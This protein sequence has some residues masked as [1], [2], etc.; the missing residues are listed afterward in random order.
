MNNNIKDIYPLTPSQEGM[1]AQYFRN[2]DTKTYHLQN[3][4][5]INK[6]TDIERLKKSVELLSLRHQVLKSAFTVLKS[7]AIKQ[8]ILQN[9]I[10]EFTV[11]GKEEPYSQAVLEETVNE[12][13]EKPLDLQKDSLFRV[14]VI[15]FTDARFVLMH[16]HHI[17][18]DGWCL[19][20]LI[21]DLQ[22][23]YGELQEGKSIEKLTEEIKSEVAL[24]TSYAQYANWIRKQNTEDVKEYW[25]TLLSDCSPAHIFGKEKKDNSKNENI[26][27]FT[28]PLSNELSQHIEQFARE[29]RVSPN[30]VFECVFSIALQKYSGS[31]DILFDKIIS[32]RSIPLKN[33]ENT[34]GPFINTVPVRI[35]ANE[36]STVSDLLKKTQEQ[37]INANINGILPL[38]EI[39]KQANIDAKSVD[40]LFVFENYYTGDGS[41]IENGPLSPK[42]ISF[43]E[44]TEFNLTVTILKDINGYAIRASYAEEMYTQRE[45]HSF[46]NGYISVLD[47]SLNETTLIKDISA[48]TKE[49]KEQINSFNETEYIY[50]IEENTTLYSLFESQATK[51]SDKVCI[52]ANDKEITYKEF[53]EF[54]ERIDNNI[55][56]V[57][58]EEKSVIAV[59]CERSFE[60]YGAIYGII[61]GGNAYLPIDPNYPQDRI[62]YILSNSNA[63]AVVAQ[64]E[65]CHL[66][67][68]VSCINATEV[69][70]NKE[71]I[72]E[73]KI[74]ANEN[75]TA[76]VIYTSGSTGNPKGAKISH[77]SAINRILWMH[78][79]Y[80]LEESDVILQKT[81]YTFDVSVWELFWWGI[82]GRTLCASKPDEHFL[83]AKILNETENH[84]VTHLHF[85]PSVFDLFLTYLENNPDE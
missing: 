78:D 5:R 40:A 50:N 80:P 16:T 3:L 42:F 58:N 15:D 83:P 35:Q 64:N 4:S 31:E 20:V 84:K 66:V 82:T 27:T 14:T 33:I 63:K 71:T 2:T 62:D 77:K 81:P 65:F 1:Y 34:V 49:E 45:I 17:I 67:S 73:T 69:L 12:A 24:E 26:V 56:S 38:A 61:R 25:Q 79:F 43:D 48:I 37:T 11:I 55:R 23:Y 85:V 13:T 36:S 10:P 74:L 47:S 30:S 7:G 6:G 32:G 59:I 72:K 53:K 51:N 41:E 68:S 76:Y 52:K 75:D 57:T 44:Q 39:Y 46:L 54:A 28:T 18:L 70:N 29:T 8:V 22:K 9:R 60:M 19:P 21:T